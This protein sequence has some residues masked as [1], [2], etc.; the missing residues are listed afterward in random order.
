MIGNKDIKYNDIV[1]DLKNISKSYPGV[2]AL[3]N[4]SLSMNAAKVHALIGENG[5]G[6]STLIKIIS[7]VIGFDK[8]SMFVN[9]KQVSYSTPR[10][11]FSDG[12]NVV[13]QE[14]NV[15]PT[16]TVGENIL[17]EKIADKFIGAVNL[18]QIYRES[19][20]YIDMVGLEASPSSRVDDLSAAEIQ[21]IEIAKALSS[22]AN[23]L[24]LDEPTSS[25]SFHE[26]NALLE[27]I[28]R[29][30]DQGVSFLY[31]THKLEEV[32]EIANEVTVLRD[33]K[34]VGTSLPIEELDRHKLASLMVGRSQKGASFPVRK[35]ATTEPVLKVKNI[36]SKIDCHRKSFVLHEGEIV[37][38]YGLVGSGRTELARIL[39]GYDP[40][41]EGEILL[42]NKKIN[43]KSV[44][45]ALNMHGIAYLSESRKEEGLFLTKSITLNVC[46]SI[47]STIR[48]CCGLI[49]KRTEKQIAE[50]YA[51]QLGIKAPSVNQIVNSLS[52]GNQQK[53]SFAKTLA[54]EPNILIIDEP[55]VGVDVGTK[56]QIHELILGLAHKNISIIVISS[57]MPEIVQLAD[58]IMV[59][60]EGDICGEI[61]NTKDYKTMSAQIIDKCLNK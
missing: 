30:R 12:I 52:G 1:L 11:A 41:I 36:A 5:A 2:K 8:G 60:S 7:G 19:Q 35:T 61:L 39:I 38:W 34:N 13:H 46:S 29:L 55:T 54:A 26:A 40:A 49:N 59:F 22:K 6:K 25:L 53:V 31:V 20:E 44:S 18:D 45:E 16:F 23:I 48:N 56:R 57:D 3:N 27:T 51:T 42:N 24:L 58:R 33:G 17:L 15:V 14:R 43:I 47:W 21:L 9:S 37:G 10:E 4:V 32:F 28:K 50:G